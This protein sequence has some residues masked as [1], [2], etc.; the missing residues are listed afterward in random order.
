MATRLARWVEIAEMYQGKTSTA[1][2]NAKLSPNSMELYKAVRAISNMQY[3]MLTS[4]K[5]FFE[6]APLD[7]LGYAD[8]SKILKSE[9]YVTNQLDLSRFSKGLYRTLVMLNLYGSVA[10][11]S[12][13]EPLRSS[14]LGKKRYITSYRPVS[15][16][17]CAFSLDAYDI[18]ESGWVAISDIQSK[19][20]L[21]KL[22]SH[23]PDGEIYNLKAIH[24][25][26]NEDD[27]VPAV[28]TWVT[29]RM[30]WS[31]YVNS[32]FSGGI[33]RCNYYGPLECRNDGEEYAVEMVNGKHI[34]RCEAFEG[35]RPVRIG[36]INN[37]D[38]EPLGNGQGDQ[39]RPMLN[40]LDEVR[41]S[42]L[43]TIT[44]AGANMFAKQ[45]AFGEESMEFAIRNFGILNLENPDLR[46]VG[47]N[48]NTIAALTG[49]E[50]AL[51]NQFRQGSGATDTLQ[52]L[53]SGESATATEVSLSMN[54][55]VRNISVGSEQ[56][57]PV[58]VGD[59][60]KMILQ[61][62]QKYQTRPFTLVINQTPIT[63]NPSDLLVDVDV[64]VK[65][66]TDQDFR[67][68]KINKLMAAAQL[69]LQTPVNPVTGLKLDPAPVI[70][71]IL[72]LLD[73]PQYDQTV[74][75]V[76]DEDLIRANV[77]AQMSNAN[78]VAGQ[79]AGTGATTPA[80]RRL[81]NQQP[82]RHE[83]R[84]LNKNMALPAAEA[85]QNTPAGQ[86]LQ[87][88]GDISQSLQS[89]RSSNFNAAQD[90]INRVKVRQAEKIIQ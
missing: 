51:I 38:V 82:G 64:R 30:A 12:Q 2:Q 14:F 42:L 22:L 69:I 31:G 23:D 77:M 40:Q 55:A 1:R 89:I 34:V 29:Q 28:N 80:E 60:I 46:P 36:T 54:E 70:K 78:T 63:I 56:I 5:P 83:Q 11:H 68:A 20:V 45:K 44:F 26:L 7:V 9:H 33:D 6:L 73:V 8:P 43:N 58:L 3:R 53:V 81:D 15:L 59:H 87:A 10:V 32:N 76:N 25:A 24:A 88:P 18:E 37:L 49:Y 4:Q 50:G 27:Y 19:S 41:S 65:T 57:A 13:Y 21:H 52:A 85:V 61:N 71:E 72:K 16:I 39:F 75:K 67:P 79:Q 35:I 90:A 62:G 84:T 17:N 48:P 86:V 66:M 74:G 47:P